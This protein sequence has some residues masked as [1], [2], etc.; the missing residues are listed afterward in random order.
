MLPGNLVSAGLLQ[1]VSHKG[2][3]DGSH[4]R[5]LYTWIPRGYALF[6]MLSQANTAP[7]LDV[8]IPVWSMDYWQQEVS[9]CS[10]HTAHHNRWE[11]YLADEYHL[12]WTVATKGTWHWKAW[13]HDD[14]L[15]NF[16]LGSPVMAAKTTYRFYIGIACI[17]LK[18]NLTMRE[19]PSELLYQIIIIKW[20]FYKLFVD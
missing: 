19:W 16:E 18:S 14:G 10:E 2:V 12:V 8:Q 15:R 5:L 1:L 6:Q 11:S 4:G 13:I 17:Y 3:G 9:C 20:F 7:Y